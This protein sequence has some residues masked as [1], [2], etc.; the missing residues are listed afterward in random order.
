MNKKEFIKLKL[1]NSW[2]YFN[3]IKFESV[4]DRKYFKLGSI[5]KKENKFFCLTHQ[6]LE[7]LSKHKANKKIIK[8]LTENTTIKIDVIPVSKK[9]VKIQIKLLDKMPIEIILNKSDPFINQI[10]NNTNNTIDNNKLKNEIHDKSQLLLKNIIKINPRITRKGNHLIVRSV[11][12]RIYSIDIT[13]SSVYFNNNQICIIIPYPYNKFLN[14]I[15]LVI[16][17]ALILAYRP[18]EIYRI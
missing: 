11:D 13:T 5:F 16:S 1:N 17:K 2:S 4:F 14:T 18:Q 15:D 9:K 12:K 7:L 6:G 10:D 3:G 8:F